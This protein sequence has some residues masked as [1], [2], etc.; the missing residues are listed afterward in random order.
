MYLAFVSV[1]MLNDDVVDDVDDLVCVYVL[2]MNDDVDDDVDDDAS[3]MML[4]AAI[5]VSSMCMCR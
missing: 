2:T 1:R 4:M 3:S 5:D